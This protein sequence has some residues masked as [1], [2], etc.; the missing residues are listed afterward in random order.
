MNLIEKSNP[1][2]FY[3]RLYP[4]FGRV[5]CSLTQPSKFLG[6]RALGPGPW[7]PLSHFMPQGPARALAPQAD[8]EEEVK[9][10]DQHERHD[11]GV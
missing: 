4:L 3:Q 7:D 2:P 11:S 9:P 10:L 6:A 1:F 8:A 5:F